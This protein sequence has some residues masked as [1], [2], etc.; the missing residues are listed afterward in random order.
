[1]T[2][3]ES[4]GKASVLVVGGTGFVGKHVCTELAQ[5]GHSVRSLARRRHV[6][7]SQVTHIAADMS[8][9]TQVD[10]EL[11]RADVVIALAASSLPA[12]SNAD[13]VAE[14]NQHVAETVRLAERCVGFDVQQLIF[15]S[16][17][18]TVYGDS[19][20]RLLDETTVP[21]PI[22]AYG[23]S[24]LAIE[25]YLRVL[26]LTT[27]LATLSLRISNPYGPGQYTSRPHGLVAVAVERTLSGTPITIWGD[28]SATRDFVH[29][30]DV[31]RAFA[32]AIGYRGKFHTMNIG[33]GHSTEL[34]TVL[35]LIERMTGT[36]VEVERRSERD[37]DVRHNALSIDRARAELRWS[38]EICL[39]DG[40]ADYVNS[41]SPILID[42]EQLARSPR[43]GI[44]VEPTTSSMDI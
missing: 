41:I 40:I 17:G 36:S 9:E 3:T 25:H 1:M 31:A 44:D 34:N 21:Q 7:T 5:R 10:S 4:P 29:V 35:K 32:L 43:T 28:G 39:E 42:L 13:L 16:S 12:T 18:G 8:D 23:A 20:R 33:S 38:P 27:D 11:E 15:A 37:C 14:I 26:G 19:T 22:N 2:L 24:K 6:S 30:H